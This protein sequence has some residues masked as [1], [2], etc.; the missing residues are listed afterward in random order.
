MIEDAQHKYESTIRQHL[1]TMQ[2]D[3]VDTD[4][5]KFPQ[6][7]ANVRRW[8]DQLEPVLKTFESRPEF[9]IH[10]YSQKFLDKISSLH[11]QE[12]EEDLTGKI[13]KFSRLV[14]GQPRWE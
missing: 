7:Y 10:D 4:N 6:L 5:R 8:Q 11:G 1:Q 14:H 12:P 3:A 2:K 13:I 9:N